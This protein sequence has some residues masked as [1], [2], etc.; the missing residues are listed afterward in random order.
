VGTSSVTFVA[1]TIA[2]WGTAR[3]L[4]PFAGGV[5]PHQ[6]LILLQLFLGVIATTGLLLAAAMSEREIA[7]RRRAADHAVTHALAAS[8]SLTEAAPRILRAVCESLGWPTG[9]LWLVDQPAGVLRCLEVWLAS[10]RRFSAFET[11]TRE[12]AF[13]VGVGLPGRV[14]G[15]GRA[16]WILDVAHDP[17]FPRAAIAARE[18][19]HA[20]FGFPIVQA[21]RVGGVVEFFSEEVRR[22]DADLLEMMTAIGIQIGQFIE[23]KEGEDELAGLLAR[24]QAARADAE[25]ASRAKDEFLAM[26]GHELRNPLGAITTAV[27]VLE[28][29]GGDAERSAH[30]RAIIARQVAHL[31][32]LVNDLLDVARVTSGKIALQR[33]AVDLNEIAERCLTGLHQARRDTQHVITLHGESVWV[34]G[35]PTRLEQVVANLLDNAVKYTP[36]GGHIRVT[37]GRENDE[38]VL[39]VQDTG[40]GI[41]P[42][43]LPRVF[44]LF[45]QGSQS[46]DRAQGGLGMGLTLA[47]RLVELHGGRIAVSSEGTGRGS[48]FAI[49]LPLVPRWIDPVAGTAPPPL[50]PPRRVLVI[51]DH[52]DARESLC[53]LLR[54]WGHDVTEAEDGPRGLERLLGTRPDVALVDVGLPGRDGYSLARAF[55]SAAGSDAVYLVALTG[56]GQPEDRQRAHEAG[57]D[58]HLVKPVSET[59]LRDVLRKAPRRS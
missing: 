15:D 1:S 40:V 36:T 46:L 21:G 20:A 45:V 16:A 57:F 12:S 50:G 19:L 53:M 24:E 41:A 35:D 56:Y 8:R 48:T 37:V 52:R 33:Q 9:A 58:A 2:I 28:K 32:R 43:V 30:P 5:P 42:D 6:S 23:R 27:A 17:N 34:H 4:G 14:W 55:R 11:A 31:S 44:E 25:A 59:D 10:D 51:E 7:E 47:K 3:G 18:G 26:L 54:Q 22:P 39:A 38:A 49:R 13:P 29:L